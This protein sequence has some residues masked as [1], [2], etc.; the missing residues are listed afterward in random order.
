MWPRPKLLSVRLK[1]VKHIFSTGWWFR[2]HYRPDGVRVRLLIIIHLNTYTSKF[3]TFQHLS[4]WNFAVSRLLT[5]THLEC[6]YFVPDTRGIILT[7]LFMFEWSISLFKSSSRYLHCFNW[8]ENQPAWA[9]HRPKMSHNFQK[10][11]K[12]WNS[13][14]IFGIT[15]KLNDKRIYS[16]CLLGIIKGQI[17]YFK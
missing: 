13:V 8:I 14:T 16:F 5:I 12:F 11:S 2:T 17:S 6:V 15:V 9:D 1:K 7:N 3:M 4:L 10:M